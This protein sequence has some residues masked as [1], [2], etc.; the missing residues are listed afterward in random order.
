MNSVTWTFT[1]IGIA[2]SFIPMLFGFFQYFNKRGNP[3]ARVVKKAIYWGIGTLLVLYVI[4]FFAWVERNDLFVVSPQKLIL[5]NAGYR[6]HPN[7]FTISNN[8]PKNLYQIWLKLKINSKEIT[9]KDVLIESLRF[10]KQMTV[11]RL[12]A[13]EK[14]GE[15]FEYILIESLAPHQNFELCVIDTLAELHDT[16][17]QSITCESISYSLTPISM[18]KRR[19]SGEFSLAFEIPENMRVRR[20]WACYNADTLRVSSMM[21]R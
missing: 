15:E 13:L 14:H 9:Y 10:P 1:I 5:A 2:V 21:L 11:W 16:S 4:G 20:I 19:S 12:S 3:K 18:E 6:T 7:C 8:S 17:E